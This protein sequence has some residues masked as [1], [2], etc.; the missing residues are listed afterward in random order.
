MPGL[1]NLTIALAILVL[2][3]GSA[4]AIPVTNGSF[5][6]GN[7]GFTSDYTYDTTPLVVAAVYDIGSDPN[8]F[9]GIN[10][11]RI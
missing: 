1:K 10:A 11:Y 9:F 4:L 3:V 2:G 7:T 5:E 6:S 8:V